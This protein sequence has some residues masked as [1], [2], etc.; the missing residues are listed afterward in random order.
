MEAAA[1]PGCQQYSGIRIRRHNKG[2]RQ[3]ENPEASMYGVLSI[4]NIPQISTT[5]TDK[6]KYLFDNRLRGVFFA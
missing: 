4:E 5:V 6:P 3:V 2:R 1:R